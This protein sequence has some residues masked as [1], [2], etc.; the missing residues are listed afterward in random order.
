MVPPIVVLQAAG[1]SP[2][3]SQGTTPSSSGVPAHPV[4]FLDE[5]EQELLCCC[6]G[7]HRYDVSVIIIVNTSMHEHSLYFHRYGPS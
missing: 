1:H 4:K 6:Q 5:F 3:A 2:T 7:L